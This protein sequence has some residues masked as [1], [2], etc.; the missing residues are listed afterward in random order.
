[1][2]G[3]AR[4]DRNRGAHLRPGSGDRALSADFLTG[5]T[6]FGCWVG[7]LYFLRFWRETQDR[8]FGLFAMAFALFG[9]NRIVFGFLSEDS[10]ARPAIYVVRLLA[11]MLIVAAIVEKNRQPS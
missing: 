3:A 9:V 6:A 11:F 2:A 8:F 1:V 10:E 7:A 5:F 4:G